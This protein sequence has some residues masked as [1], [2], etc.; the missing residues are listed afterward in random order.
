L[1]VVGIEILSEFGKFFNISFQVVF[2]S[3]NRSDCGKWDRIFLAEREGLVGFAQEFSGSFFEVFG[4]FFAKFN[5]KCAV[6]Y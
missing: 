3:F 6:F 2:E 4:F 5:F 1:F